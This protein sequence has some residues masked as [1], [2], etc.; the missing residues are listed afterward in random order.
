MS[1]AK[2]N[3]NSGLTTFFST[4]N[5]HKKAASNFF[6]TACLTK[7]LSVKLWYQYLVN[8]LYNAVGAKNICWISFGIG[9][10]LLTFY[11]SCTDP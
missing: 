5:A 11:I 4:I 8:H 7:I 1:T 9:S 2:K 6:E 3:I 10:V